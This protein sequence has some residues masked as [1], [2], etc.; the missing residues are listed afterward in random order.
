MKI[1]YFA[2]S[3]NL[4]LVKDIFMGLLIGTSRIFADICKRNNL[5]G[6]ALTL[7]H[8]R[9]LITK[10]QV[11]AEQRFKSIDI[12][13]E[14]NFEW[15]PRW[16]QN[17][18]KCESFLKGLGFSSVSSLDVSTYEGAT[19]KFDLN[20]HNT[21]VHLASKFD[22]IFDGSTLE[23]IFGISNAIGHIVDMLRIGGHVVHIS[24]TNN[25]IDDGFYQLSPLFFQEFYQANGFEIVSLD[26]HQFNIKRN[27]ELNGVFETEDQIQPYVPATPKPDQLISSD[28]SLDKEL[29]TQ[30]LVVAKKLRSVAEVK[31]PFQARYSGKQYWQ[32]GLD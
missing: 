2:A 12:S 11:E 22:L 15:H 23:H 9:V 4:T 14:N 29:P 28:P 5:G 3:F 31:F 20:S 7:G 24:P 1:L 18:L 13:S 30:V 6:D 16:R 10:E 8:Q 27:M 19:I 32:E 25:F 17:F 26:Y 21:P